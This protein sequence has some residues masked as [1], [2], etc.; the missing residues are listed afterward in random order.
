MVRDHERRPVL[1]LRDHVRER[2]EPRERRVPDVGPRDRDG[3][4]EEEA[5]EPP[6]RLDQV[7]QRR[8]RPARAGRGLLGEDRVAERVPRRLR[9]EQGAVVE[10]DERAVEVE[11]EVGLVPP[12]PLGPL[13]GVEEPDEERGEPALDDPPLRPRPAED[14]RRERLAGPRELGRLGRPEERHRRHRA[15]VGGEVLVEPERGRARDR[16]EV[17]VDVRQALEHHV[18]PRRHAPALERVGPL[19]G[20]EDGRAAVGGHRGAW[21]RAGWPRPLN[22]RAPAPPP[23]PARDHGG[24]LSP[25]RSRRRPAPPL[26]GARP[27]ATRGARVASAPPR[28]GRWGRGGR[29]PQPARSFRR[30]RTAASDGR[31]PSGVLPAFRRRSRPARSRARKAS[32]TSGWT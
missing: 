13:A 10:A 9:P 5:V 7:A 6:E 26:P 27:A 30:S 2:G 23:R 4:R 22:P 8:R 32:R 11:E 3:Q 15:D 20:D 29:P 16:D 28:T 21:T 24:G 25:A 18:G 17:E 14:R 1:E 19:G 12:R 31:S